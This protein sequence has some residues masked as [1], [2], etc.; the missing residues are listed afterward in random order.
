MRSTLR[1]AEDHA[2]A[3]V[4]EQIR[5]SYFEKLG[6]HRQAENCRDLA[7]QY[8]ARIKQMEGQANG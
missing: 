4:W 2:Y 1:T 6:S 8:E 5:A 7:R 3:V